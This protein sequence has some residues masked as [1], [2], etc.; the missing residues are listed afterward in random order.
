MMSIH[1]KDNGLVDIA[2]SLSCATRSKMPVCRISTD[3]CPRDGEADPVA[4][5][6][7]A[8]EIEKL[9]ANNTAALALD[10]RPI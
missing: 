5:S 6:Q 4:T 3:T 1:G 10:R 2:R 7:P 9:I 8:D